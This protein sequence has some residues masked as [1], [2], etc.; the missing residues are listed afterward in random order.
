MIKG[1]LVVLMVPPND[2]GLFLDFDRWTAL[3]LVSC[4]LD[5]FWQAPGQG[6]HLELRAVELVGK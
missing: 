5:L 4:L 3:N 6:A 1:R 2:L